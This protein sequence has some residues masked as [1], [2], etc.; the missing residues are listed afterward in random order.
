M[1][2]RRATAAVPCRAP[3]RP[4]DEECIAARL[5]HL[6][7]TGAVEHFRRNLN[8]YDENKGEFSLTK[9]AKVYQNYWKENENRMNVEV[10]ERPD[11]IYQLLR[12]PEKICIDH[13]LKDLQDFWVPKKH[14]RLRQPHRDFDRLQMQSKDAHTILKTMLCD[15]A[16][17]EQPEVARWCTQELAPETPPSVLSKGLADFLQDNQAQAIDAGIMSSSQL[18]DLDKYKYFNQHDRRTNVS[19]VYLEFPTAQHLWESLQELLKRAQRLFLWQVRNRFRIPTA[20]G[21][22][23][24][25]LKFQLQLKDS[26]LHYAELRLCLSG[27]SKKLNTIQ[28]FRETMKKAEEI[29]HQSC[30]VP[31]METALVAQ[32]LTSM[33]RSR[34][35]R[36]D[37]VV[38]L[39]CND[40]NLEVDGEDVFAQS[41]ELTSCQLFMVEREAGPGVVKVG[42]RIRLKSQFTHRYLDVHPSSHLRCR[43]QQPS[44]DREEL[45]MTRSICPPILKSKEDYDMIFTVEVVGCRDDYALSRVGMAGKLKEYR[46]LHVES[47]LKLKVNAV[48]CVTV[49]M[50]QNNFLTSF[51]ERFPVK[52][53]PVNVLSSA[54]QVFT[55]YRDGAQ[56]LDFHALHQTGRKP[57][58]TLASQTSDEIL[59]KTMMEALGVGKLG[60]PCKNW[61]SDAEVEHIFAHFSSKTSGRFRRLLG[62]ESFGVYKLTTK[63]GDRAVKVYSQSGGC[64]NSTLVAIVRR[65]PAATFLVKG[66]FT[67][68]QKRIKVIYHHAASG[69]GFGRTYIPQH[70]RHVTLNMVAGFAAKQAMRLKLLESHNQGMAFLV[71]SSATLLRRETVL[72][73][74]AMARPQPARR[75][76][77][78]TNVKAAQFGRHVRLLEEGNAMSLREILAMYKARGNGKKWNGKLCCYELA[79]PGLSVKASYCGD[80]PWIFSRFGQTLWDTRAWSDQTADMDAEELPPD[81]YLTEED[82]ILPGANTKAFGSRGSFRRVPPAF[83]T[84]PLGLVAK[85]VAD[86]QLGESEGAVSRRAPKASSMNVA[87]VLRCAY[88]LLEVPKAPGGRRYILEVFSSRLTRHSVLSRIISMVSALQ[89][90]GQ[91]LQESEDPDITCALL[92][93]KFL[94]ICDA[95]ITNLPLCQSPDDVE[96]SHQNQREQERHER[97]LA[98]LDRERIWTLSLVGTY[99]CRFVVRPILR[100][101]QVASQRPLPADELLVF[102]DFANLMA[103]LVQSI[104]DNEMRCLTQESAS[105]WPVADLGLVIRRALGTAERSNGSGVSVSNAPTSRLMAALG[106]IQAIQ[107][108][109]PKKKGARNALSEEGRATVVEEVIPPIMIKALVHLF[110]YA[111][112]QEAIAFRS[113]ASN[114]VPVRLISAMIN[115][116]IAAL[117]ALMTLTGS[118][119]AKQLP[120][121]PS[122]AGSK[123]SCD[124]D[125]CEAVSQAMT[126]GAQ[127]VPRARVAQLQVE[128]GIDALRPEV[129]TLI[130]EGALDYHEE[131]RLYGTER[132]STIAYVWARNDKSL[133]EQRCIL[134]TTSRFRL[135]FLGFDDEV[136]QPKRS[137]L[138][139]LAVRDMRNI[140]RAVFSSRIR[141]FLCLL[142]DRT[143]IN[144]EML[145][146]ESTSRRRYFQEVLRRVPRERRK[147]AGDSEEVITRRNAKGITGSVKGIWEVAVN[148]ETSLWPRGGNAQG[149]ARLLA[150]RMASLIETCQVRRGGIPL[151][152][153]C[154]RAR[155]RASLGELERPDGTVARGVSVSFVHTLGPANVLSQRLS[156][157]VLTRCSLTVIPFRSFWS[158][159]WR[160]NVDEKYYDADEHVDQAAMDTDSDDDILPPFKETVVTSNESEEK[161][162]ASKGP[163][164]FD[165][166]QGVW[167]FAESSPKVRLQ[168]A[169]PIDITFTSDGE[170]QRFRRHLA[171]ILS[172]DAAPKAGKT[173]QA[174]AGLLVAI[175]L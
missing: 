114:E 164:D 111:I 133:E 146:F 125:V 159:F 13:E 59:Q 33:L 149:M 137:D 35:I 28:M 167:F 1:A 97:E 68:T 58:R 119:S 150:P 170:R 49:R 138:F 148:P 127:L 23:Y 93:K 34:S 2:P 6:N 52:S 160:M 7:G 98:T 63:W 91:K 141:Q 112:H 105:F 71:G 30:D 10:Q 118:S 115:A 139:V 158:R 124:Y 12:V 172:E 18:I 60:H 84:M 16:M 4:E 36:H 70:R 171:N 69:E 73:A 147:L 47:S 54:G 80:P 44:L 61:S 123:I 92:P 9:L 121:E 143:E 83:K 64:C 166:L 131:K 25:A 8:H 22:Y 117:A 31:L 11:A 74:S 128:R 88:M 37:D 3:V 152:P 82:L 154:P 53:E 56:V 113:G 173:S 51:G 136:P 161:F 95:A 77:K 153:R 38:F 29:L 109:E 108:F 66:T 32:Y 165:D 130:Q 85:A 102:A 157:L 140:R 50:G 101:L 132:V 26:S 175:N 65:V 81:Y 19:L 151:A 21:E 99:A 46:G 122:E 134:V 174:L 75:C 5:R 62:W 145:I 41:A 87:A 78:K 126:E 100:K 76:T 129:Q 135:V 162:E 163:F 116:C 14:Q 45:G 20:L 48:N 42:D 155:E 86:G 57:I 43:A 15:G 67:M 96:G 89:T 94:R 168:F 40:V 107:L 156:L 142:W 120:F 104:F 27:K 103:A 17:R 24:M 90:V 55:I 106:A 79:P 144:V 39:R 72:W 169:Q 110:L